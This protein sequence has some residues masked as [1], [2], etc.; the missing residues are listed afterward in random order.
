MG[1]EPHLTQSALLGKDQLCIEHL[2]ATTTTLPVKRSEQHHNNKDND[3][4]GANTEE[5]PK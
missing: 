3:E 2:A 5:G 4:I 1:G